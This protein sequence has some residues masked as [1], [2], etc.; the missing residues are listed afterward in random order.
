MKRILVWSGIGILVIILI[1][2]GVVMKRGDGDEL[3]PEEIAKRVHKNPVKLLFLG[4]DGADWQ[5][6]LPMINRGELPNME[7]LIRRGSYGVLNSM[8]RM[9]SPL[10]WTTMATGKSP[11]EHGIT[12]YVVKIPG[13]SKPVPIGS[14]Q[15]KV[16]ALWNILSE[17]NE[18][19]AFLDWWASYPA[20]EVNG[21][22][23]S[24]RYDSGEEDAI[25]PSKATE[26]LSSYLN[27]T[28]EELDELQKR[29]T[30]YRYDPEFKEYSP[31]T[32]HYQDNRRILTL[33]YH[34]KRDLAMID[35]ACHLIENYEPD[36]VSIYIKGTDGLAHITWKYYKPTSLNAIFDVSREERLNF[37]DILPEY[38]RW[39]DEQ[40]GRLMELTDDRYTVLLCS[41]HGFCGMPEEINYVVKYLLVDLGYSTLEGDKP[42]WDKTKAYVFNPDWS[43]HRKIY[44]NIKGREDNG[45]IEKDKAPKI[46]DE[47]AQS[48]AGI[49]NEDGVPLF[50]KVVENE[51]GSGEKGEEPPDIEMWFNTDIDKSDI[52]TINGE[53]YPA[54]NVLLPR[55]LSGDHRR[56]GVVILS[57]PGIKSKNPLEPQNLTQICP[58][59]LALMGYPV[60]RDMMDKPIVSAF[61]E[62]LLNQYP[63]KLISSYEG[64]KPRETIL[65]PET[66]SD[67]EML[68]NLRGLGYIE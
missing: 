35:T 41:D 32:E 38:Y 19:V 44:L 7:K 34:L 47:L 63:I 25:Y 21:F 17:Y 62:E 60:A 45:I 3:T 43:N 40:M 66:S 53:E 9:E 64:L 42:N 11:E 58:T 59:I 56:E 48:L 65:T 54:T 29:F 12:D 10:L 30:P 52:L 28:E 67:E 49:E 18:T 46:Q 24:D 4:V 13:K 33:R 20:E 57:G 22:I 27:I 51:I 31:T 61:T 68:E 1:I 5:I 15:R 37:G 50:E 8:E 39:L 2:T 26:E 36:I 14:G 6:L 23:V 16:K 55:G